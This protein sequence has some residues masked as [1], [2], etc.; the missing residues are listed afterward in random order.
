M[1]IEE[2]IGWL[3]AKIELLL[4][5]QEKNGNRLQNVEEQI[6]LYKTIIKVVK[7]IGGA[8]ILLLT[9]KVGDVANLWRHL[10]SG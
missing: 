10:F 9:L 7:F 4:E 5:N 3:K 8:I 1:S 2:D 6:S